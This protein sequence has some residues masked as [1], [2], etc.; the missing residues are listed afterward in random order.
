MNKVENQQTNDKA[1]SSAIRTRKLAIGHHANSLLFDANGNT[2]FPCLDSVSEIQQTSS[3]K[4]YLTDENDNLNRSS[5]MWE[6]DVLQQIQ[7]LIK[8]VHVSESLADFIN[9]EILNVEDLNA[10]N[11]Y[12]RRRKSCFNFNNEHHIQ[13]SRRQSVTAFCQNKSKSLPRTIVNKNGFN[14]SRQPFQG[15]RNSVFADNGRR[16]SNAGQTRHRRCSVASQFAGRRGSV[17]QSTGQTNRRNSV[18]NYGRRRSSLAHAYQHSA[19]QPFRRMSNVNGE[20]LP[21]ET[22]EASQRRRSSVKPPC[23]PVTKISSVQKRLHAIYNRRRRRH[24]RRE[25]NVADVKKAF[26]GLKEG[27]TT[28]SSESNEETHSSK[29]NSMNEC[30]SELSDK[31]RDNNKEETCVTIGNTAECALNADHV[32]KGIADS[33]DDKENELK[34]NPRRKTSI[35]VRSWELSRKL[36]QRRREKRKGFTESVLI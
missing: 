32:T 17:S 22:G 12:P 10:N 1:D 27:E 11:D 26:K 29:N 19:M 25:I 34:P 30:D 33:L 18:A 15:R 31:N 6:N 20:L 23:F 4:P 16:L 36:R 24:E 14:D 5:K 13:P 35:Q 8:N 2:T 28:D 21:M 3:G 7:T 9:K